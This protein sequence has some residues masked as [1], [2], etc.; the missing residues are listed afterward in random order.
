VLDEAT[1]AL[2]YRTEAA[3]CRN[4]FRFFEGRTVFFVTHRLATIRPA[5]L[6][7][8]MD[9]GIVVESG[10]YDELIAADGLF[11]ALVGCQNRD[12]GL[13]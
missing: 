3:V 7:L 13:T 12:G 5:D 1:S 2:D 4:L 10:S 11:S 8:M 6:I 9:R